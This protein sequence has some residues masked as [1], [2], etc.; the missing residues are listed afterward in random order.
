MAR[1]LRH[2]LA[3]MSF[4]R[5]K[6]SDRNADA[7]RDI[8]I[9]KLMPVEEVTMIYRLITGA[10]S[11]GCEMFTSSNWTKP[12]ITISKAIELTAPEFGGKDFAKFYGR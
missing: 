10:C 1:V 8:D 2:Y 7:Y 4:L 6:L 5:F 3:R 9:D 12:T 11:K